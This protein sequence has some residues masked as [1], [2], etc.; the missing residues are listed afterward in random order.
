MEAE[1]GARAAAEKWVTGV[2]MGGSGEQLGLLG[3]GLG[4]AEMIFRGAAH[5]ESSLEMLRKEW[6]RTG[7]W[8]CL[9]LGE[10]LALFQGWLLR[11]G[12]NGCAG[13]CGCWKNHSGL[14]NRRGEMNKYVTLLC[15]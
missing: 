7:T 11:T 12:D 2:W 5:G 8:C 10:L 15:I 3:H 6:L 14:W 13:V 9:M 1:L 4:G